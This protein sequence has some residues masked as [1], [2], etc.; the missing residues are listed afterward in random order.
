MTLMGAFV[1]RRERWRVLAR[2]AGGAPGGDGGVEV[3]CAW[4]QIRRI[5]SD[6]ISGAKTR[7]GPESERFID[8]PRRRL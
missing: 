3:C 8:H 4:T 1:R 6:A 5:A 2:L 7:N